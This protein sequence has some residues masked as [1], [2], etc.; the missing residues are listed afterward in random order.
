MQPGDAN[1]VETLD[2]VPHHLTGDHRLFGH[3]LVG[4]AAGDNQNGAVPSGVFVRRVADDACGLVENRPADAIPDGGERVG[5]GTGH[6]QIV[7]SLDDP[8]GDF[9]DLIRRLPLAEDNFRKALSDC[10][11]VV[12]PSE[13]DI[14]ERCLAHGGG[15]L[16]LG[17]LHG[18]RAVTHLLEQGSE[19]LWSHASGPY[20][21]DVTCLSGGAS[22]LDD[23]A[24]R[25]NTAGM[26]PRRVLPA[27]RRAP[28]ST[29]HPSDTGHECCV[30]LVHR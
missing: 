8:S 16:R 19:R 24:L 2:A 3:P 11:V 15:Q 14:L 18:E 29:S 21:R 26:L 7:S 12:D 9:C 4:G 1:V 23:V 20:Q 5:V 13:P 30:P 27:R 6:Q 28:E 22:R 10:P 25:S 17:G